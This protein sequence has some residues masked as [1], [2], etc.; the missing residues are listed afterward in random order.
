MVKAIARAYRV[1]YAKSGEGPDYLMDHN[2]AVYLMNPEGGFVRLVRP[3][4][5]PEEMAKE[6]GGAIGRS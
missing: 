1:Y 3:D 5:N 2:S 4:A 6:I